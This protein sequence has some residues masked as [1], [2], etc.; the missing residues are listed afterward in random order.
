MAEGLPVAPGDWKLVPFAFLA[1]TLN[2]YVVPL[3][4]PVIE[5][6][7]AVAEAVVQVPDETPAAV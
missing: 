7:S 4:S 6:E 5:H 1:V 3:V 2:V